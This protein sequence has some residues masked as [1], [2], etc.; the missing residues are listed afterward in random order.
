MY[1][2]RIYYVS[3]NSLHLSFLIRKIRI[4]VVVTGKASCEDSVGT[5]HTEHLAHCRAHK[6]HIFIT[7][8]VPHLT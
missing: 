4:I 3:G 1:S 6:E 8:S 2:L 7:T 5:S